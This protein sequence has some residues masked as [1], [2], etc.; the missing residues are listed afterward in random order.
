MI[1]LW[2]CRVEPER[3]PAPEPGTDPPTGSADSDGTVVT[4]PGTGIDPDDP[5]DFVVDCEGGGDFRSIGEAVA[6]AHS[7]QRIGLR[8]CVYEED[9]DYLGKALDIEGLG[10]A[11]DTVIRGSGG[12][13]VVRA[14]RGES[15][16]TR[17]ASV[18]LSGGGGDYGS[19]LYLSDVVFQLEDVIVAGN[20]KSWSPIYHSGSTL[21]MIDVEIHDNESRRQGYAFAG[22]NGAVI[23]QGLKLRCGEA[24]YG[25][26]Q[27][28]VMLLLDSEIDCAGQD[29]GIVVGGG[30]LHLRRSTVVADSIG[31]YGEDNDDTR[32]E[33]LYVS[34]S[35]VAADYAV[36]ALYMRLGIRNSVLWGG[37]HGLVAD[38]ASPESWFYSSAFF[39]DD[40]AIQGDGATYPAAWNAIGEG[41]LC[42]FESA[43]TVVGD[44]RFVDGP[45]DLHLAEG[46]P[47]VDAG[48]PD[49]DENDDDGSRND[50]GIYG[51]PEGDGP[52]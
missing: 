4:V 46:S 23:A 48:D 32:N 26:Y 31:I 12:G 27:H 8:P 25:I 18:T 13:P 39:G 33:R 51:G 40:C 29:Y 17:L 52:R 2:A 45:D 11:G 14:V 15:V 1:W 6:A 7:G 34:N 38:H 37:S 41:R 30:E 43:E 50:I 36:Y 22:D 44:P 16:G 24:N 47:L 42:D 21:E 49:E 10:G 3:T 19:A 5:P 28:L 9:V 35:L 20:E